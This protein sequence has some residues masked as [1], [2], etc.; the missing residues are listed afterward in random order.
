MRPAASQ[1]QPCETCS[2]ALFFLCVCV[3]G[4]GLGGFERRGWSRRTLAGVNIHFLVAVAAVHLT[5]PVELA[6]AFG[7]AADARRVVATATAHDLAAVCATSRPV[8]DA[9]PGA[10]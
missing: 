3:E 6:L 10:R 7:G 9:A 5:A 8:A 4:W 2:I 1:R